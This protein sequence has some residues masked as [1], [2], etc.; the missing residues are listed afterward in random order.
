MRIPGINRDPSLER[1]KTVSTDLHRLPMCPDIYFL[2]ERCGFQAHFTL[3][4]KNTEEFG[5]G[6][7]SEAERH[8]W[9]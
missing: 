1:D 7:L 9:R 5:Q 2:T 4:K 6:T 3:T 8:E